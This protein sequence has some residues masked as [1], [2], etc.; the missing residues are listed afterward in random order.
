MA[1]PMR[2]FAEGF[3]SDPWISRTWCKDIS[4]GFNGNSTALLSSTST[5][6]SWPRLSRLLA[7]KVSRCGTWSSLCDPGM[8]RIAPFSWVL[9][10]RATQAVTTSGG[11][12][13]QY[14]ESWCQETKLGL[15][16]SLMKKL[17]P[18]TKMLGPH[19]HPIVNDGMGDAETRS[20]LLDG[21]SCR[22][23]RESLRSLPHRPP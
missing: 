5:M 15:R 17:L 18:Q 13:P 3:G 12:N 22:T 23:Y 14:V 16:G 6:I 8:T 19:R 2:L 11:S 1:K 7:A 20:R 9:S 21:R 10:L 4:P